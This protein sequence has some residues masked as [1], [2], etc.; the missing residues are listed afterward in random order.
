MLLIRNLYC[1]VHCAYYTSQPLLAPIKSASFTIICFGTH[2]LTALTIEAIVLR[3]VLC[4]Q[5][6]YELCEAGEF[7]SVRCFRRNNPLYTSA[8]KKEHVTP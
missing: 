4:D 2:P 5:P 3:G 6:P 8:L 1:F 7:C